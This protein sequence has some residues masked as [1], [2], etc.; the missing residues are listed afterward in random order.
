MLQISILD[1]HGKMSKEIFGDAHQR[2]TSN[3]SG[4]YCIFLFAGDREKDSVS[5]HKSDRL[6]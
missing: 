2:L 4:N 5:E 3:A 6:L 1:W